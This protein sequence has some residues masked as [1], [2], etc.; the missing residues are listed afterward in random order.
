MPAKEA[1][2]SARS[3]V[4]EA[5]AIRRVAASLAATGAKVLRWCIGRAEPGQRREML[6]HAVAHVAL[7]A[8]AG[9]GRPSR[10]IS[11]SRV[12]L[13]TIEAAA[14]EATSASPETTASQS[15]P[16][17]ILLLPSTKTIRGLTGSAFTARA[18]AH[19]EAR[20]ILSRS[21]RATEPK[22]TATCALAQIFS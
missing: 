10:V 13:A 7:E 4:G 6:G 20:K 14:T 1:T 3:L 5:A 22:A 15:Q 11:R 18:S 12:T 9:I 19:S 16:Q 17:S 21:T 2:T 8:V